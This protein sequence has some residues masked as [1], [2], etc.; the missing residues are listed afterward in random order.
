VE[1]ETDWKEKRS[2]ADFIATHRRQEEVTRDSQAVDRRRFL[3]DS[4]RVSSVV[5]LGTAAGFLVGRRGG[6]SELRWQID[7]DEC[8][9][10]GNCA[11]YCVL[12]ESAV[13]CVQCFDM[14]GYCD[15]CTGYFATNYQDI[16]TAAENQLCP[17]GAIIRDFIEEKAGQGFYEYTID[18][19]LCIGCG[20]CVKGCALMNGS[21]YLQVMQD[22]C[23]NCNE[24][25]IAVA[26]PS[27]AF[28]RVPQ[29]TPYRLKK[30]A[31]T[32]IQ[33]KVDD[34]QDPQAR[35]LLQQVHHP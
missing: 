29:E 27:R 25:A 22:R 33:Q 12:D 18:E 10:C 20:K 2:D 19:P 26:C 14:C 28:T 35:Q 13:R 6:A 30:Q 4:V 3:V 9:G 8:I 34:S 1:I 23:V 11:T 15:I 17:T 7:P 21:L 5:A 32:L 16:D 31:Y 24:C